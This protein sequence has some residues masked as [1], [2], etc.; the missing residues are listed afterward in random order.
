MVKS[1]TLYVFLRTGISSED[2]EALANVSV[3]WFPFET[4]VDANATDFVRLT[5]IISPSYASLENVLVVVSTNDLNLFVQDFN[6]YGSGD[7]NLTYDVNVADVNAYQLIF[8]D[9][10]IDLNGVSTQ[11]ERSYSY[12]VVVGENILTAFSSLR[13]ELGG[14]PTIILALLITLIIVV[15]VASRVQL[16][17]SW[18]GFLASAITGVFVYISWLPFEVWII[19]TVG[20]IALAVVTWRT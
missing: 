4:S 5:Q 7:W 16:D 8:V 18:L 1:S 19:A 11:F 10:F 6:G 15:F 17:V 20:V 3:R 12:V 2:L 9:L 14:L 13:S